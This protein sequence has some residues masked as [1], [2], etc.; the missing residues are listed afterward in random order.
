[1][2]KWV[3]DEFEGM[4]LQV[5]NELSVAKSRIHIS[6]DLWTS[7]NGYA[8]CGICAHFVGSNNRNCNA[9]I[10]MKRL[11]RRHGG[12][13]I[14]AVMIPVLEEYEIPPNLGVFVADNADSND[15]AIRK[16]L[17]A[18]RPDLDSSRRRSRCLGHIINLAAKA[19]L[20]GK[21][22]AA[23]EASVDS[24]EDNDDLDSNEMKTAQEAWR[25]KGAIG[26]F[27][28]IVV[29]IRSSPQRREAFKSCLVGDEITDDLMVILDNSTRWNSTYRS[30]RR[31][32]KLK[33]R[34]MLF[35]YQNS[36]QI[37]AD[38]LSEEDWKHIDE[39]VVGLKPFHEATLM[40]EG[41]AKKGYHG[42]VWEVLPTLEALLSYMEEGRHTLD[43]R[44]KGKTPL[45]MAYQNAWEKLTKY[46]NMTDD[47]HSIY[48]AATLL[49]P[50]YRKT[51][52]D[53]QWTSE[54]MVQWKDKMIEAVRVVW[55]EEYKANSQLPTQ[56]TQVKEMTFLQK[57]LYKPQLIASD[58]VFNSFIYGTP[59]EFASESDE[60]LIAWWLK[61]DNPWRPLRQQ[62]LD[63]LS[64]PAMSAEVERVFSSTKRLLTVDRNRLND[65]SIEILQLLKHW[66][67]NDL[68]A[69]ATSAT[70][71]TPT[72]MTATAMTATGY[73]S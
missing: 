68:T 41:H 16:T 69:T 46:Y 49:H 73:I 37:S 18:V 53:R 39:I 26:K 24:L 27:H 60:D 54:A 29:F 36:N 59:T 64:I 23:F 71:I 66:W 70:M 13:D 5:K 61:V 58:D 34:L 21:D 55:E 19:F 44:K 8:I 65:E 7:P 35:C 4:R 10:A 28:N 72:A 22:T 3:M 52:F 6:F 33:E 2:R 45:A 11:K 50:A 47:S 17:T 48:A 9:L 12:E 63:L 30:L 38:K 32:Q 20:F 42:T 15:T 25:K 31:G 56:P 43:S 62:A 51:Y 57:H 67:T 14:A 40:V 1:M